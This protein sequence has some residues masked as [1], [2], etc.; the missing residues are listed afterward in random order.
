MASRQSARRRCWR[1]R[2]DALHQN[3]RQVTDQGCAQCKTDESGKYQFPAEDGAFTVSVLHDGGYAELDSAAYA[4]SP[5]ITLSAWD[6]S[7]AGHEGQ[8]AGGR[9]RF[10]VQAGRRSTIRP[11]RART[12]RS[13]PKRMRKQVVV[14]RVPPGE[15]M[16]S[17]LDDRESAGLWRWR[18]PVTV[19]AGK[20]TTVQVG[21]TGR[22]V[23]GKLT[24]PAGIT[25]NWTS[26]QGVLQEC[27][28]FPGSRRV[29]ACDGES[30]PADERSGDD[31][32]AETDVAR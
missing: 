17:R 22:A 6:G 2:A 30:P 19:V 11:G 21:G 20:T 27:Q 14:D 25:L 9:Q 23:T 18:H 15:M 24:A 28:G 13:M 12:M 8:A 29:E 3:A 31:D 7:R 4:K 5:D 32:P 1:C 26:V 16:I 10:Q